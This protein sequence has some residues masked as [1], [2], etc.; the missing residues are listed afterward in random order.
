MHHSTETATLK[1]AS[2]I[3]DAA[4]SGHVTILALLDLNAAFDTVDHGILQQRL[5]YS[6]GIGGTPLHWIRSFFSNQTQVVYYYSGQQSAQLVLTCGVPQ[7]SESGPI[8]FTLS[9]ADVIRTAHSFGVNIHCYADD[10]Q[11]YVHCRANEAAAAVA[12]IIAC[13]AATETWMGS[14]RLK[15]NQEKIQFIWLGS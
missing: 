7:G 12:R 14:N 15:M 10:L 8:M 2:D 13:I 5:S 3:F 4:D 6:Y 1:V 11:L 9:V